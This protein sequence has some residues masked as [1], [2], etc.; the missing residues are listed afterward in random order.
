MPLDR[1]Q[2]FASVEARRQVE[3]LIES[4]YRKMVMVHA[5]EDTDSLGQGA[6][7][8]GLS[9]GGLLKEEQGPS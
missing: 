3:L 5:T 9:T 6:S 1:L 4:E 2:Q 8:S 7:L